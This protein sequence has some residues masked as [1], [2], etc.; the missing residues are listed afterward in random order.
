MMRLFAYAA[1]RQNKKGHY[2]FW[3]H[4]N[5]VVEVF[6]NTFIEEKVNYIHNNPVRN[7]IVYNPEEYIY[8]SA[9]FYA[10][11]ESILDVIPVDFRWK[12][13]R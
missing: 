13:V 11:Q 8:S 6:S 5:Y 2:Q 3:T 9:K 7:G 12:T 4:E 1:K 10:N